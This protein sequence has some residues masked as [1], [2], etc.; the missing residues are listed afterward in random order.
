MALIYI[1]LE[2]ANDC[3]GQCKLACNKV[4]DA[5]LLVPNDPSIL[6]PPNTAIIA[7]IA[8]GP[9][10]CGDF[11]RYQVSFDD[12]YL[13]DPAQIILQADFSCIDC[14]KCKDR[15]LEGLGIESVAYS[16][17]T[18]IITFTKNDGTTLTIDL[19]DLEDSTICEEVLNCV[20]VDPDTI[21]GDG[22][23]GAPF[24]AIQQTLTP[25][26]TCIEGG[27]GPDYAIR[28]FTQIG[29]NDYTLNGAPEHKTVHGRELFADVTLSPG[30]PLDSQQV[31]VNNPSACRSLKVLVFSVVTQS[32]Q[33]TSP[34]A[35]STSSTRHRLKINGVDQNGVS[36]G[37]AYDNQILAGQTF[38]TSFGPLMGIDVIAPG[39]SSTYVQEVEHISGPNDIVFETRQLA[40]IGSTD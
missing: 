38:E 3:E 16:P 20:N 13:V 26:N 31:V 4:T 23:V 27:I 40:Y 5:M 39:G 10:L 21:S 25:S 11:C 1:N 22:S 34:S 19:L 14:F 36:A 15:Y 7:Y 17:I 35:T 24:S 8:E 32:F 6:V 33:S 29:P 30:D 9:L 2:I 12:S 28:D 37:P 18:K